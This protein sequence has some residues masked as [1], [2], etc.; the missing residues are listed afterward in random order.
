MGNDS[1]SGGGGRDLIFGGRGNDVM[2]GGA[3]A[4]TFQFNE[5][6][7]SDTITDF[8][9][10]VNTLAIASALWDANGGAAGIAALA[11]RTADGVEI[12]FG[13][14]ETILLSGLTSTADLQSDLDEW[15]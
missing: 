1:L 12:D 2:V 6:S 11:Q 13:G 8:E 9:I 3:G 4:D 15:G 7:I 5:A 14:G 10:G